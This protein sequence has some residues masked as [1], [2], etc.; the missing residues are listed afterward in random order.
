[1]HEQTICQL[2]VWLESGINA[3]VNTMCNSCYIATT[4]LR[5]G[6]CYTCEFLAHWRDITV[7]KRMLL[8]AWSDL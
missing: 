3:T 6:S 8:H 1:M 4:V 5:Y 2:I 7:Y